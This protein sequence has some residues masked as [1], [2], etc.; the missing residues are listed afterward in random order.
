M[1]TQQ[2]GGRGKFDLAVRLKKINQ[3]R[4][5]NFNYRANFSLLQ[6]SVIGMNIPVR[7]SCI[8]NFYIKKDK[9]K[10]TR[11]EKFTIFRN[12]KVGQVYSK[13]EMKSTLL[14]KKYRIETSRVT[15]VSPHAIKEK[16]EERVN[17][18]VV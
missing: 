6:S 10:W 7:W 14:K 3:V 1:S 12:L 5:I 8:W 13:S 2:D 18:S 17:K 9:V 15:R 16:H 4:G 11:E